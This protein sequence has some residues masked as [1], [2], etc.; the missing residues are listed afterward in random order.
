M[1][2]GLLLFIHLRSLFLGLTR[3][4]LLLGMKEG[5][6]LHNLSSPPPAQPPPS[7]SSSPPPSSSSQ[8]VT[9]EKAMEHLSPLLED[10]PFLWQPDKLWLTSSMWVRETRRHMVCFAF[11]NYICFT[12]LFLLPSLSPSSEREVDLCLGEYSGTR[13][14]MN[15][16]FPHTPSS[17]TSKFSYIQANNIKWKKGFCPPK[18]IYLCIFS[19]F[20]VMSPTSCCNGFPTVTTHSSTWWIQTIECIY[21][22]CHSFHYGNI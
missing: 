13:T 9:S 4:C 12:A 1:T 2:T 22:F 19:P 17:G 11:C 20:T 5:L 3:D 8:C 10:F 18:Y 21:T 14:C 16:W 6:F 15:K 7:P